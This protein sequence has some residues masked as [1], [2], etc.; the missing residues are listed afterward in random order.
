M[1]YFCKRRVLAQQFRADIALL[2]LS[3]G[4]F[5]VLLDSTILNVALPALERD[6][7]GSLENLQW[8]LNIY[9]LP[10]ASLLLTGGSLGDCYGRRNMFCLGLI[11]FLATSV[12]CSLAP[13]MTLLIVARGFQGI[14]A[15][16]LLPAS[17]A[18]LPSLFPDPQERGRAI[19]IWAGVASLGISSGPLLGGML[20]STWG[21]RAI[22]LVNAPCG[23]LALALA[24]TMLPAGPF[25]KRRRLDLVG[26]SLAALA[27]SSFIYGLIEWGRVASIFITLAFLL[28]GGAGILFVVAEARNTHPM[29]PLHLFRKWTFSATLLIA[30]LFQF[31]FYGLLFSYTFFIQKYNHLSAFQAGVAFLPQTLCCTFI[32]LFLSKRLRCWLGPTKMLSIGLACGIAG[33]LIL[34]AGVH[35][36]YIVTVG[37]EILLGIY[38]GLV[39]I[40]LPLLVL[41]HTDPEQAGIASGGLN[42][43]RQMGGALGVAL[44]GS[45]LGRCSLEVGI[46]VALFMMVGACLAGF[47]LSLSIS[48][49]GEEKHPLPNFSHLPLD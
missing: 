20:V 39:M 32:L 9:T 3:L 28:A 2:T 16:L 34:L 27:C 24:M 15:A 23:L 26:Q 31:S 6:F 45:A 29:F 42:A 46:Q 37:A 38:G 10:F 49:T 30:L 47:F 44:L 21:W 41:A 12:L 1:Y 19:A 18:L 35:T 5:M 14:G 40:P 25:Q 43:V 4:F 7:H 33:L 17:L 48:Q 36:V 22:F 11:L 13:S 8:V